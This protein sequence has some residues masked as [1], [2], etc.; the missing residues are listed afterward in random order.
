[1]DGAKPGSDAGTGGMATKI[2][3]AEIAVSAGTATIIAN[4][5]TESDA[6]PLA[7]FLKSGR[8][9]LFKAASTPEKARRQWISARLTAEGRITVDA[10]AADALKSGASLLPAGIVSA[11]GRF[12]KGDA[13]TIETADGDILGKGL[14]TYSVQEVIALAGLKTEDISRELGY[15]GRPAVIHRDDLVL[16][17]R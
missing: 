3:A 16:A 10:G 11:S 8:A 14:T 1:M 5:R 17:D 13:V 6:A 4:G 12:E 7:A 2:A 9:T 15:A